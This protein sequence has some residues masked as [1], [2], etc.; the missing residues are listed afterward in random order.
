[1]IDLTPL[2]VRKKKGDFRKAMRG[3]D[4]ALVD[5]FLDLAADRMEQLVRENMTLADRSSRLEAQVA[6]F[7]EREKALTEALVTAQEMREEVRRAAVQNAELL[8][9]EAEGEAAAIR[10]AAQDAMQD[11]EEGLRR[12]RAQRAQLMK[13]FRAFLE[14]EL[15][16]LSVAEEAMGLRRRGSRGGGASRTGVAPARAADDLDDSDVDPDTLLDD[17]FDDTAESPRSVASS[18]LKSAAPV[19]SA[20]ARRRKASESDLVAVPLNQPDDDAVDVSELAPHEAQENGRNSAAAQAGVDAASADMPRRG[21]TSS[22]AD[23]EEEVLRDLREEGGSAEKAA[24][25]SSVLE[26]D[27]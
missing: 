19:Q 25:L 26:E 8:R 15:S 11:E 20:A 1:M 23:L 24:L 12:L 7:R 10:R 13:S 9:R 14:R 5:D 2:E 3:Y 6:D 16:E 17:G 22:L 4:P 21:R 18:P 27:V